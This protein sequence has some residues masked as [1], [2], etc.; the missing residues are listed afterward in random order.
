MWNPSGE[1]KRRIHFFSRK[2][3][4][5]LSFA[6]GR[7]CEARP[8]DTGDGSRE[9]RR[10]STRWLRRNLFKPVFR[11][12]ILPALLEL[13]GWDAS[14]VGSLIAVLGLASIPV[15]FAVGAAS[16]RVSDRALTGAALASGMAG[17]ALLMQA[18]RADRASAY[19]AGAARGQSG[20]LLQAL[21]WRRLIKQ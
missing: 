11:Q 18:G 21:V 2:E 13:S 20:F 14:D 17:C 9:A 7:S 3:T 12:F 10:F 16:A 8:V 5:L 15:S 1:G 4:E 19:F 6:Q